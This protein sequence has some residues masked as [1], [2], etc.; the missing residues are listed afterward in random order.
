MTRSASAAIDIAC[1]IGAHVNHVRGIGFDATCSLVV[2]DREGGRGA[3]VLV[4]HQGDETLFRVR[5]RKP[6]KWV[7]QTDFNN[8]E[9]AAAV[10]NARRLGALLGA[11]RSAPAAGS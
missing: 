4:E 5:G 8:D 10:R 11:A 7:Q 2:R 6:E 9:A 3:G 1:Q